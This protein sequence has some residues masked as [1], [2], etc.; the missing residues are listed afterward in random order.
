MSSM[1]GIKPAVP[2][3][4][5][6]YSSLSQAFDLCDYLFAFQANFSLL[7]NVTLNELGV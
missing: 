7:H 1:Y 6:K 5:K 2:S 4:L 3:A